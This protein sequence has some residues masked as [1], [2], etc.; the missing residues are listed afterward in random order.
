MVERSKLCQALWLLLWALW[1]TFAAQQIFDV[2]RFNAPWPV[3]LL[4]V[5]PLVIFMPG[6]A[7]GN[8]RAEIW[9]CFVLLFYFVSAVELIFA[10]P[11]DGIAI[12]GLSS[13]IGL[14]IV[15]ALYI[16]TRGRELKAALAAKAEI[17]HSSS[18]GAK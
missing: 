13:V 11:D 7:R 17:D 9:L 6:V 10:A 2:A 8:L 4:R 16:R 15:S 5:F 1:L 14:F 18:Q 3:W 12:L